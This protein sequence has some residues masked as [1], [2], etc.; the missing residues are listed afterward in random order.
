MQG[1]L[2]RFYTE[3]KVQYRGKPLSKWLLGVAQQFKIQGATILSA[4][5]S[6]GRQG[7]SHSSRFFELADQPIQV[8]LVVTAQQADELLDYLQQQ[9]LSLF[10]VKIPVEFGSLGQLT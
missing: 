5:E 2:L 8:E 7:E 1:Y 4:L 6:V 9:E 3:Q 10:Y